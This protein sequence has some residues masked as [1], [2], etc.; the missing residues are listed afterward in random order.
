[1]SERRKPP[2][3]LPQAQG[4]TKVKQSTNLHKGVEV[5]KLFALGGGAV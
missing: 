4:N 5:I 3:P 1:M 2:A